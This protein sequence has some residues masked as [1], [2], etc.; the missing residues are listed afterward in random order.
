MAIFHCY[1]SSPEGTLHF[2]QSRFVQPSWTVVAG[3][4]GALAPVHC[5]SLISRQ[6]YLGLSAAYGRSTGLV[7]KM[8]NAAG[9]FNHWFSMG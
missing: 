6:G 3:D 4:L 2:C 9:G 5:A 8:W 1:V 7:P